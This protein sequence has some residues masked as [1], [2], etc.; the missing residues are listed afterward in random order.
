MKDWIVLLVAAAFEIGW[1]LGLKYTEGFR[2]VGPTVATFASMGLSMYFLALAVRGI[3][4][5]T[6]Y[7]VWT[8][9]GAV[10]AAVGGIL[11]F[12]ESHEW[13]RLVCLALI[14]SGVIGLRV[15]HK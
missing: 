14:V 7:A 8:G 4:I 5:G 3:P 10:G 13:P 15:F 6:A 2:R 9:I 11:L 12:R 1:A